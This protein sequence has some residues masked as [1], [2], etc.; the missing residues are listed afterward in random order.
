MLLN[1][2]KCFTYV[3]CEEVVATPFLLTFN[4]V[5]ITVSFKIIILTVGID[6]NDLVDSRA[7]T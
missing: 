2:Y 6:S 1:K 5:F 7:T 3:C 4:K